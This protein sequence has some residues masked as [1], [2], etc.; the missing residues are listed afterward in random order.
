MVVRWQAGQS[1]NMMLSGAVVIVVSVPPTSDTPDALK[2]QQIGVPRT[3]DTA[4]VL[5]ALPHFR[6]PLNDSHSHG[7]TGGRLDGDC[8][9]CGVLRLRR[10]VGGR[11]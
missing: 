5:R 6:S 10:D 7:F 4:D 2:T 3:I 1:R 8:D 9:A 11:E